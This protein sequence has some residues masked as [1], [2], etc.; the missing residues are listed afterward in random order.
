PSRLGK[1]VWKQ[2]DEVRMDQSQEYL[3]KILSIT[4]LEKTARRELRW[5]ACARKVAEAE[6]LRWSHRDVRWN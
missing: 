6:S 2:I 4:N 1:T 5:L 3:G